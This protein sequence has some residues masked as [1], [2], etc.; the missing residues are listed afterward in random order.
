[1]SKRYEIKLNMN[2]YWNIIDTGQ[3]WQV[4]GEAMTSTNA[5]LIRNALN[6]CDTENINDCEAF[7]SASGDCRNC[8]VGEQACEHSTEGN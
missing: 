2:H 8:G 4:V 1:M 7:N 6:A 3:G 5:K